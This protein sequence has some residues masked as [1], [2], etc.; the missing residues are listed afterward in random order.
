MR[1]TI[2]LAR[3]WWIFGIIFASYMVQLG[4]LKLFRR[5]T[6]D[7]AS[8]K[9]T[10]HVPGWL[11]RRGERVDTRNARRLLR[12]M[13]R[14][15]GVY[16][17]LGQVL[18]IMGGFLP[19]V[20]GKELEALQD[21]VPPH[22]FD[23]IGPAIER[24]LGQPIAAL[25]ARV[26]PVPVAA[27]SL[28]QVHEAY[29]DDGTRV[30][31]KVLYPG[32][33][34]VVRVDMQ[35]VGL[36]VRVYKF[37]VPMDNLEEV[38]AALVDLLRRETDY[39]HEAACME[40]MAASFAHDA[41][42]LFPSVIHALSTGDVL[43]MSF[44]DGF[45]ITRVDEMERR[46]IDPEQVARI[47]V[48]TF[49]EQLFVHRFFHADPHP[50]NFLIDD[51]LGAD[52]PRVVVLDFG[53]TCEVREQTVDG[54]VEVLRGFF[55][56]D[57]RLVMTGIERMGFVAE[58]GNRALL[59]QTVKVYFKKILGLEAR[60]AGALMR[61]DRRSLER[62]ARRIGVGPCLELGRTERQ[63]GGEEKPTILADAMEA[64]I[65]ALYLDGGLEVAARFVRGAFGRALD[66]DAPRVA[67][68]PKTALQEHLM[69]E[70]GEFPTY[71]V[72]VDNGLEGDE[73]R[74][75]VE[76]LLQGE[77]LARGVGRSKRVAERRAAETAL[78]ARTESAE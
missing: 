50:G 38:H 73:A 63:S 29:L 25:F 16:I 51:A 8:G 66:V 44:M 35:V 55:E 62:L 70:V 48:E 78:E 26:D 60:T 53:A 6:V 5:T 76:V 68:D 49:Y 77:A 58:G 17:K 10:D 34:G 4:L 13:L 42:L 3:A 14:L 52:E 22:S 11:E 69:A 61:A 12:G 30:A 24:S 32:I 23:E 19:R 9:E 21:A 59:E 18:S 1:L 33:R 57:D 45:K 54:M 47:L 65:G 28:G 67:R 72:V 43:T 64:L 20:Y 15:R 40:R 56:Q 31:V 46:G 39:R 71:R 74:F 75:T 7:A 37:F 41:R 36:A 2:R 27:A